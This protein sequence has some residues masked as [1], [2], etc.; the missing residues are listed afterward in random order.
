MGS[1]PTARTMKIINNFIP[2]KQQREIHDYVMDRK[3]AYRLYPSHIFTSDQADLEKMFY[4]P[5][6]FSHQ[7]YMYGEEKASPH[8]PMAMPIL[9]AIELTCGP[10]TL[11]RCKVNML[12][13]HPPYS[14]YQSHVPHTDM[15]YDDGTKVPHM[16][17]L[18]YINESDGP[19][20]F[21][22]DNL[23]IEDCVEPEA[24]RAIIFDGSKLHASSS[25][26]HNPFRLIMNI[27]FRQ[28]RGQKP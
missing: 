25:P 1:I 28:G 13:P 18:Y 6:Q 14:N 17:C 23:E 15:K 11:F 4:S 16:V 27:D 2:E 19:T 21:F 3:F 8:L 22:N 10:I 26:V 7:M 5:V 12:T 24:G 9:K 20:Y